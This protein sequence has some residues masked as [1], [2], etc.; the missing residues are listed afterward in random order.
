MDIPACVGSADIC[1]LSI[2]HY[3]ASS[4]QS[5]LYHADYSIILVHHIVYDCL[6]NDMQELRQS[7]VKVVAI[8]PAGVATQMTEGRF[9]HD[10]CIQTTD[11]AEA[12]LLALRTSSS[13]VPQEITLRLTLSAAL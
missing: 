4:A 10:R 2:G 13:C 7:N 8:H 11:I 1:E 9:D 6:C 5:Q 12:A 3:T